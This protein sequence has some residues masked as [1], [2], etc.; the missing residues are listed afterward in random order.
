MVLVTA[1]SDQSKRL[2]QQVVARAAKNLSR[3]GKTVYRDATSG[4]Y[5]VSKA[6]EGIRE[7]DRKDRTSK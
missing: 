6:G 5:V 2:A 3:S 4:R 1:Y 7:N